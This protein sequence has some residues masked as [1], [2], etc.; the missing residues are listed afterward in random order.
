MGQPARAPLPQRSRKRWAVAAGVAVLWVILMAVTG[1]AVTATVLLIVIAGL[2][3][4]GVLGLRALGGTRDHPRRPQ[5]AGRPWPDEQEPGYEFADSGPEFMHPS[6][7]PAHAG[8][9]AAYAGPA[10]GHDGPPYW[11]PYPDSEADDG[12]TRAEQGRTVVVNGMPTVMEQTRSPIPML[13]LITGDSVT[14]TRMSGARAGRGAVELALPDVPTVSREH[15]RFTFSDGQWRIANLGMNGLTING[16]PVEGEHPLSDGDS[17]RWGMRP[18][19]LLSRV[20]I[21]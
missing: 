6:P 9:R 3:V 14:E 20:E 17:I 21:G 19:A 7:Q 13:R 1:S 4:A 10:P 16:G 2:G 11:D 5:M 8:L 18:D 12:S 15:A